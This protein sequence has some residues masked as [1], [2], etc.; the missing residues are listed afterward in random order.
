MTNGSSKLERPASVQTGSE[1]GQDHPLTAIS[2]WRSAK[3]V[4][5][6]DA[7]VAV[8]CII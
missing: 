6:P 4:S 3:A 8:G 2:G 1:T 5:A 7:A